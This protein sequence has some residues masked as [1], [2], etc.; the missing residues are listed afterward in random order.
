MCSIAQA[1]AKV[2]L[3]VPADLAPGRPLALAEGQSHYLLRVMRL[4]AGDAIRVFN[5]R[6]GEWLARIERTQRATGT[7][8]V[9]RLV[10]PQQVES[11]PWLLFAPVKKSPTDYIVEKA[12]ELGAMRIWPVMTERTIVHRVN[13]ARLRAIAVEATEQCGRL[14]VPDIMPAAALS[15][16]VAGWPRERA[17]LVAHP[18][19]DERAQSI[20]GALASLLPP[21][22]ASH[23]P[24]PAGFLVGP[25]G[26]LTPRELDVLASLPCAKVV[27]LGART[28]RAETAAAALLACWQ[29][30]VGDWR[31]GGTPP[32]R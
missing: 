20:L 15:E 13:V 8:V 23:T 16:L 4:G 19:A 31:D 9:E 3:F 29:A 10:C 28:L 17:L 26:G 21:S 22:S 2:R 32:A 14:T 5:G 1:E 7:V 24:L 27:R 18:G 12:A 25:E 30:V 6:D 11:G